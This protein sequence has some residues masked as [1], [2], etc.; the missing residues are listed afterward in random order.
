MKI[1]VI[2]GPNINM[3]GVRE[4]NIYGPL[5]MENIH[6]HL[7]QVAKQNN[8]EI[9]F[10]QSNLEGEIVDKIQEGEYD[11]SI[12]KNYDY[13]QEKTILEHLAEELKTEVNFEK[14]R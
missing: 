10:F 5:K 2:Q 7:E 4:Q 13:I 14:F 9:E 12:I 8:F 11:L 1:V 6:Q 3:L